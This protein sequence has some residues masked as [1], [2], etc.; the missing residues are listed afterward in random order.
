M[1]HAWEKYEILI[2]FWLECLNGRDHLEDLGVDGKI[3][4]EWSLGKWGG[5]VW[6]GC[7]S[8]RIETSGEP[9]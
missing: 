4:L 8:L 3:K 7:I 1:H 5:K 9:F 2:I 6:I